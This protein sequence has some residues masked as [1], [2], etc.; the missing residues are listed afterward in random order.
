M[1]DIFYTSFKN[2]LAEDRYSEYLSV[3]PLDLREK[4]A[5]FLRWKDQHAHLFGKLLLIEALKHHNIEDNIWDLISYNAHKRPYFTADGYDF[6]ISHSGEYVLCAIGK[7]IR[8]GIDIEINRERNFND[9]QNLMT[10]TQW[11]EINNSENPIQT[12]YKYWTIKECQR[13]CL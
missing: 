11:N 5:R 9:F 12:F 3:L 13:V 8:L 2:P 7:N 10:A 4:N 1:I 6:N